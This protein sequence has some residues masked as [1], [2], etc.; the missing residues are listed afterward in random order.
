ME[1]DTPLGPVF[2]EIDTEL[3][4]GLWHDE[5]E[6]EAAIDAAHPQESETEPA[7]VIQEQLDQNDGPYRV[8]DS[9]HLTGQLP[10]CVAS[11]SLPFYSERAI[12]MV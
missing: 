6:E 4:E 2:E 3:P 9:S 11:A 12:M 8:G 10:F 7:E 5:P 1:P